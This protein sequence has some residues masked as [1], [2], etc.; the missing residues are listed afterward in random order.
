VIA[1]DPDGSCNRL[2]DFI[3]P[4]PSCPIEGVSFAPQLPGPP[5][6]LPQPDGIPMTEVITLGWRERLALPSFGIPSL[7]AK[8]DTGARSSSL[9][10]ESLRVSEEG[11]ETWLDFDVRTG[12]RS[13]P[14]LVP[15]RALATGRRRVSDSGGHANLRWFVRTEI[16]IGGFRFEIDLN[17]NDRRHMLFPLLLG[18]MTLLDRI[19]VDP[20]LSYTTSPRGVVG[21]G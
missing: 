4:S 6:A 9:H 8:L 10:V 19:R 15:C 1:L 5:D 16:E 17:L 21:T 12:R 13:H 20:A 3:L 18:R 2:A 11:G 14:V 7:K